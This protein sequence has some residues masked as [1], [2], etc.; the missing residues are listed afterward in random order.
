MGEHFVG[1]DRGVLF[2]F[3][4][5]DGHGGDFGEDGPPEGVGEGEVDGAEFEVHAV[6]FRLGFLLVG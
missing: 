1:E 6:G 4:E 5:V 2:Y 3:D